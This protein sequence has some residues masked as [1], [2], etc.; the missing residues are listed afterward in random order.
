MKGASQVSAE[1][2]ELQREERLQRRDP[3]DGADG[4]AREKA[5]KEAERE[6]TRRHSC[7]EAKLPTTA[8]VTDRF[9]QVYLQME[10][11]LRAALSSLEENSSSV[12]LRDPKKKKKN[13]LEKE[14]CLAR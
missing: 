11:C 3:R 14:D 2:G 13:V 6:C 7:L 5:S 1:D 4:P 10:M 12:Q 9:L 8:D